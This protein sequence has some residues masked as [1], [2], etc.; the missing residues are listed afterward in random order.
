MGFIERSSYNWNE[1]SFKNSEA[2]AD[3]IEY[4]IGKIFSEL[5]NRVQSEHNLHFKPEY[6]TK[7]S[8]G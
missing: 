8:D 3:I 6:P 1:Q 2:S 5:K 7:L 4:K